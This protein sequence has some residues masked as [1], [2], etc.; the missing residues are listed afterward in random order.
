MHWHNQR[1]LW[2]NRLSLWDLGRLKLLVEGQACAP[3][4]EEVAASK[5]GGLLAG[6]PVIVRA[7]M[8]Y[9]SHDKVQGERITD[10]ELAAWWLA[11][12]LHPGSI[13][14]VSLTHS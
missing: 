14:W 6:A 5:G 3:L 9:H 8:E 12:H 10:G 13:L 7:K 11:T 4:Y 1:S 2:C